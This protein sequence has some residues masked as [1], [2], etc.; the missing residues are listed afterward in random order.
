MPPPRHDETRRLIEQLRGSRSRRTWIRLALAVLGVAVLAAAIVT[1]VV[2]ATGTPSDQTS[3]S[4]PASPAVSSATASTVSPGG[5]SGGSGDAGTP[6]TAP[7]DATSDTAGTATTTEPPPPSTT[8]GQGPASPG[9]T[10]STTNWLAS[11]VIVIDPGHQAHADYGLEPIGPGSSHKKAKVSSGTSSALTGVPESQ[12]TLEV[13]LKLR[14]A[15]SALGIKVIMTRTAQDVDVPNS[16]RA[17]IGNEAGA[18]LTIRLHCNGGAS[19]AHGLFTLYPASI[20]GWTDD[21][22]A[23]SQRAAA[24]VQRDLIAATGAQDRGLQQRSDLTG[25]NWS[26]VPV[27]LVEMGFMSNASEDKQ[28]RSSAY[29]DKIVQGFVA[30]VVDYLRTE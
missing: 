28:L 16:V 13:G 12:V 9:G 21:I 18:D 2:L 3:T 30:A 23:A 27:V 4:S 11:K 19:S 14:D 15:L 29:Q 1:G 22:F 8:A 25:F 26:D 6:T 10:T 24:I 5:A 17:Q 20:K 7:V